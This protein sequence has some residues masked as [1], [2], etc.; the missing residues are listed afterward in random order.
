MDVALICIEPLKKLISYSG[1]MNDLVHVSGEELITYKADRY[2]I[3]GRTPIDF[4]FKTKKI[5]YKIGDWFY[6]FSDGF[7]DQFGGPNRKKYMN[8]NFLKLLQSISQHSPEEQYEKLTK[9]LQSWMGKNERI[10]DVL[11]VG[12]KV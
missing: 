10:D 4:Q 1:A 2:A 5:E 9:E 12:F 11:V 3:G 8:A 6:M 7:K